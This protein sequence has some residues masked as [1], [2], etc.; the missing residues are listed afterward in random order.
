MVLRLVVLVV[1][2]DG[3]VETWQ[4]LGQS[5]AGPHG[6]VPLLQPHP[7]S[8]ARDAQVQRAS[9]LKIFQIVK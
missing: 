2:G 4:A 5:V 3:A 6:V 1:G 9:Q 7:A 8:L